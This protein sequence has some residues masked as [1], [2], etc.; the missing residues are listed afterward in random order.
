VPELARKS[1]LGGRAWE[2]PGLRFREAP[3]TPKF[4]VCGSAPSPFPA[5]PNELYGQNPVS[6]MLA[7]M[8]WMV[9]G[10][11][12]SCPGLA[13]HDVSDGRAQIDL[14]GPLVPELLAA[15]TS[16]D[17]DPSVFAVRR[18]AQTQLARVSALIAR[19]DETRWRL[20]VD[21]SVA[22]Y[23]WEWLVANGKLVAALHERTP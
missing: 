9:F 13:V 4:L 12:P 14:E 10:E 21:A 18:A 8:R 1:P 7:P 3:F 5:V 2:A 22:A 6:L 23:V 20:F 17:L 11:A 19:F 16:V 15:G